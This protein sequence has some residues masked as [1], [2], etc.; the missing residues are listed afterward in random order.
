MDIIKSIFG[1]L[2]DGRTVHSYTLKNDNGAS[3]TLLSLGG[4]VQ[5]LI[6]PDKNGK[7]QDVVCG[8]DHPQTY[9]DAAGYQGA[10]IGRVCNRIGGASF[11][12]EGKKYDLYVNSGKK[13]SLHGGKHGFNQKIWQAETEQ[14]PHQL[15]IRFSTL[16]PDMEEGYPGNLRVSVC[17]TFDNSNRLTL[18]YHATTDKTTVVNLTNHSYFNLNGYDGKSVM[19]QRL[20]LDCDSYLPVDQDQIPLPCGFL[21]VEGTVFDF[22]QEKQIDV[23]IDHGFAVKNYDGKLQKRAVLTDPESGRTLTLYTDQPNI[24]VYTACVMNGPELFKG[25]VMQKQL[26]A[27]CLETQFPSDAPN[28]PDFLSCVLRPGEQ[29][30]RTTVFAFGC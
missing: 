11:T 5:S 3:V 24:Q 8:Y 16:S 30:D 17:Y 13:D 23:P 22:T 20:W 21:P 15:S 4:T 1:T 18:R 9:Y 12:L 28:R 27:I 10:L 6:V 25:G 29:F 2:Q 26:H 14:S 19:S 7:L